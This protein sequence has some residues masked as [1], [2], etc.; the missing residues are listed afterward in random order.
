MKILKLDPLLLLHRMLT[1]WYK[2]MTQI[3][4]FINVLLSLYLR[5]NPKLISYDRSHV[6]WFHRNSDWDMGL[7]F[8]ASPPMWWKPRK[9]KE[10]YSTRYGWLIFAVGYTWHERISKTSGRILS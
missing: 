6:L 4:R 3:Y 7:I 2:F 10:K 8:E 5:V 9:I 1:L